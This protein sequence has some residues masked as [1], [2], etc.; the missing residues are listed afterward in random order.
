MNAAVGHMDGSALMVI[1]VSAWYP[2]MDDAF[3]MMDQ[4]YE[5]RL[6]TVFEVFAI[7]QESFGYDIH[8]PEIEE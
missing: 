1:G 4:N 6:H 2:D 5:S 7:L 8:S 3:K